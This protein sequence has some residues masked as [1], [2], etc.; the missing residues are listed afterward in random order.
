MSLCFLPFLPMFHIPILQWNCCSIHNKVNLLKCTLFS[1]HDILVLQETFLHSDSYL[2]ILC[3]IMYS[4]DRCVHSGGG[5]L[6]AVNASFSSFCLS[7]F[8]SPSGNEI[9]GIQVCMGACHLNMINAY[10]HS[11]IITD[12]LEAYCHPFQGSTIILGNFNLYHLFLGMIQLP[13]RLAKFLWNGWM[14]TPSA[15]LTPTWRQTDCILS[16]TFQ[17]LPLPFFLGLIFILKMFL[18]VVTIFL[19]VL[20]RTILERIIFLVSSFV[21]LIF[22]GKWILP[23]VLCTILIIIFSMI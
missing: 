1:T 5:I 6:I 10:S 23:S 19:S 7:D 12:D 13:L 11:G 22:V 17:F 18:L 16:L 20:T 2:D 9:M 8:S 15:S 4:L 3:K 14:P 21:G